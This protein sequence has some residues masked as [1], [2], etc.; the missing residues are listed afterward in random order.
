MA[1]RVSSGDDSAVGQVLDGQFRL[2]ELIGAG[3]M[4]RVYRAHQLGVGRDVALKRLRREH[5]GRAD[6]V[7]RFRNEAALTARLFHPHVVSVHAVSPNWDL[8]APDREPYVVLEW[9]NGPSLAEALRNAGGRFPLERALHIVLALSDA[10]GEAHSQGLVHRDLKP[11]NV[12]LVRRGDDADFV[13]LLDFG[14]AKALDESVDGRTRAGSVLG[15]PRYVSPEGAEGQA[16]TRASDCYA[17]AT[18]L[19]EC[20]V[21]RTPFE[22]ESAVALLAMQATAPPPDVRSWEAT[23]ELPAPIAEHIMQNLDKRPAARSA[24]ARV[25]GRELAQRARQAGLDAIE[26][27]IAPTLFGTV[28]STAIAPARIETQTQTR[29][30]VASPA[31]S[32][33]AAEPPLVPAS[34]PRRSPRRSWR[35]LGLIAACFVVGALAAALIASTAEQKP[36]SGGAP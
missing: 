5:L 15:T 28:R 36:P 23:R 32:A 8:D 1:Q 18:I 14:L 17:L 10:V 25:F 34:E 11:E 27:G 33:P 4:A 29:A 19:Y 2:E 6:V 12:L 21:G 35:P 31:P 30:V 22:A 20:L 16:A 7:A 9:L 26:I 13:K 24:N 3:S